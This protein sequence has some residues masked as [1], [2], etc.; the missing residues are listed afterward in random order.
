MDGEGG[1][2]ERDVTDE[3]EEPVRSPSDG[4]TRAERRKQ[5]KGGRRRKK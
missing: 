2:I 3:D 1:I 4:L 5:A